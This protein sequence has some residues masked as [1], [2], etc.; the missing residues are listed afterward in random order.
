MSD[1]VMPQMGESIVEGTITR[2]LKKVGEHVEKD[3]ALFEISTDKVDSEV[4]SPVSG[5][6]KEIL[7]E[8]GDTIEINKVVARI[9]DGGGGETKEG[10]KED[11][12]AKKEEV[13]KEEK[14]AG[15][16]ED[17]DEEDEEEAREEK[18]AAKASAAE[19][20]R[21]SPLV[22]RMARE[23]GVDL[24]EVEGTGQ[25]GRISKK[26][27]EAY[28][29]KKED[30]PAA[31]APAK[32]RPAAAAAPSGGYDPF[33]AAPDSRFGDYY[34]EPIST[35]RKR[36][37]EHMV[38]SM[39]HTSPHVSMVH[40]F[41][42]TAIVKVRENSK[43]KFQEQNGIKL[44]YMPFFIKAAV[45]ALKEFPLV[46][47]SLD[48]EDIVYHR[49]INIGIAVALDWGLLVPVIKGADDL[50]VVGLQKSLND[51]AD[52]ARKKQL[53]ADELSQST[54]SIS[55]YGGYG[56]IFATPAI[57]Q[58]NTALLGLGAL[59]KAPVVVGDAIAVRSICYATLTIDHRLIDGAL[60]A[61][62]L[63]HMRATI[64]N[65]KESVL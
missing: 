65:W 37:A 51:L 57:N 24:S 26:D 18:P 1:V 62:F 34:V 64:E 6:L 35:M 58:P 2:W 49:D 13:K 39:H 25:G 43:G 54:F 5:T 31:K 21:S 36:I 16:S 17:E 44:T 38:R 27:L 30:K 42:C 9:E 40:Q 15:P 12:P 63:E 23:M 46:N 32:E 47:A 28:L 11:K 50:S 53:K 60:A 3:E 41:D 33:P 45:A 56:S 48:G 55:N 20:P 29:A 22:R 8:E 19:T 14:A 7:A 61:K 4:P 59:H 10:K 52:R